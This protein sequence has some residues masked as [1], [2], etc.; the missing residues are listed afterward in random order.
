M[1]ASAATPLTGG[2]AFGAILHGS[3]SPQPAGSWVVCSVALD[4]FLF[5]LRW[6]HITTLGL[7]QPL[8]AGPWFERRH[9]LLAARFLLVDALPLFSLFAWPTPL[10]AAIAAAGIVVDR[11]GFYALAIQHTTEAEIGRVERLLG[12]EE[13]R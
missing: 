6:R 13:P 5:L 2:I 4:A 3:L 11:F 9:E 12:R 10:A 1:G 7:E 8:G